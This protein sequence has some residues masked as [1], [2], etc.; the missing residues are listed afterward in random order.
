MIIKNLSKTLIVFTVVAVMGISVT[1]FAGKGK[2]WAARNAQSQQEYG[3]YGCDGSGYGRH[4]GWSGRQGRMGSLSEEEITKFNEE[5]RTFFNATQDLRRSIR[6]KWL[7]LNSEIAKKNPDSEKASAL[8]KE[9]SGLKGQL[10]EKRTEHRLRIS[11]INPDFGHMGLG[12]HGKKIGNGR[13]NQG[14]CR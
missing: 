12:F 3:K 2:G 4:H 14:A 5:R 10:D 6:Q 9:L 11:K 1:A 13:Y 7:E 8:Q